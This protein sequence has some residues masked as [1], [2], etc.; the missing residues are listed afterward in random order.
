N[1]DH[2]TGVF[3]IQRNGEWIGFYRESQLN[4]SQRIADELHRFLALSAGDTAAWQSEKIGVIKNPPPTGRQLYE[5]QCAS[6]HLETG[7]GIPGKYPSLVQ[8]PS[9]LGAPNGL[10]AMLLDGM[11]GGQDAS[12]AH[13]GG[14]MPA[15]RTIL[16]PA[17]TAAVLTYVR[18]SWG[19]TATPISADYVKKLFYQLHARPDFW[20]RKE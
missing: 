6:C 2:T 19:N 12:G 4:S 8:S 3:I 20:L 15:Y 5:E 17:D 16:T 13:Y 18:Q 14:V 11:K 10:T 9:V 1:I 7:P